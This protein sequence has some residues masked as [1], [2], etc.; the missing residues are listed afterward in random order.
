MDEQLTQHAKSVHEVS[1]SDLFDIARLTD[2]LPARRAL[3]GIEPERRLGQRA[4][5]AVAAA[6]PRAVAEIEALLRAGTSRLREAPMLVG[7]ANHRPLPS[8]R[9]GRLGR[10]SCTPH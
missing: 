7:R 8:A 5:C 3:I 9:R 1:L 2:S 4:L 10:Y 6:V